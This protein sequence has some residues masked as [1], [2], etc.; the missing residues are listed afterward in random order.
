MSQFH[1]ELQRQGWSGAYR[2]TVPTRYAL[3]EGKVVALD[4]RFATFLGDVDGDGQPE[5]VV[6]Y[7][8][9][10]PTSGGTP[11][12]EGTFS[13][14]SGASGPA[15][16]GPQDDRARIVVFKK[17]SA[18]HWRFWWRSPGLGNEFVPPKSNLDEVQQGLDQ[19]QNISLPLALVDVNRDGRLEIVYYCVSQFEVIG[20][21][22]GVLRLVGTQPEDQR[23]VN[24]APHADRFTVRD[25]DKDGTMEVVAGSRRVGYGAGDDDVPR[26]W[27]WTGTQ[28]QDASRSFP[29]FYAALTVTYRAYVLRMRAVGEEFNHVA[30]QRAIDKASSLAG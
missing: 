12:S 23:W 3:R 27:R 17:D 18:G 8:F 19:L 11:G 24:V 25:V 9:D 13:N 30:W 26:V 4:D 15:T 16:R 28:F 2:A 14:P 10:N 5:R 29:R 6:G 22:P 20:A 21:L 1:N 7:Y